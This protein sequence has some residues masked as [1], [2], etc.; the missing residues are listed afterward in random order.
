MIARDI[1]SS[2]YTQLRSTDTVEFALDLIRESE[3]NALPVLEEGSFIGYCSM[4]DLIDKE[5]TEQLKDI[6][7]ENDGPVLKETD[8][9]LSVLQKF[10][11]SGRNQLSV[12]NGAV[13]YGTVTFESLSKALMKTYTSTHEGGVLVLHVDPRD[14]S[15]SMISR[16]V[17]AEDAKIIGLWTEKVSNHGKLVIFMKLN[18][19]YVDTISSVLEQNGFNV[20]YRLGVQSSELLS[21]RYESLMRYLDL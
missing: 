9:Y 11:N 10:A 20:M 5:G 3:M 8:D 7:L 13:F 1:I 4:K 17:E 15:L 2:D 19:V 12:Q 14:Y 6:D 21:E 18:T 16:I